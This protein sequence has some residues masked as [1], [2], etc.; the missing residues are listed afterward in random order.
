ME[1]PDNSTIIPR[2]IINPFTGKNGYNCFGCDPGNHHGLKMEFVDEGEYVTA[3]WSPRN[4]FQGYKDVLHGGIQATL[5]DEI[6]SWYVYAKLNTAGV[7]SKLEIR[8]KKPVYVN[9]GDITIRAK[10][11]SIKRNLANFK[12][13]LLD[14]ENKLCAEAAVQYFTFDEKVARERF[15]Y[16][17]VEAFYADI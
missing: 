7:T 12:V 2:K 13:E 5:M 4:Y 9:H 14:S 1:K 15:W 17:G 10:L 3:R 8:Y 6:A 11:I 16:P